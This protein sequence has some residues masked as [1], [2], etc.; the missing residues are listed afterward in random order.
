MKARSTGLV[1]YGVGSPIVVDVEESA[2]RAGCEIV[3]AVHNVSGEP[4]IFDRSHLCSHAA[5]P[6]EA[7]SQPFLVPLF[8]PQNRQRAAAEAFSLGFA[9]PGNLIDPTSAV[10]ALWNL[11]AGIYINSGCAIGAASTLDDFVFVNR[12]A[13]I[14]HHVVLGRYVSIGPGAVVSGQ[15]TIGSGVLIGAG[16]VIMAGITIGENAVVGPGAVI[17]R[18]VPPHALAAGKPMRLVTKSRTSIPTRTE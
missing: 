5:I 9:Q 13:S 12:G 6:P 15:V 11:G 18:D 1:L 3:A 17:T 4:C 14:G 2:R 8:N 16:A 10:P 7:L